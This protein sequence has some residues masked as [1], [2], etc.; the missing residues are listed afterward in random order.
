MN[1]GNLIFFFKKLIACM[2]FY[3]D[4]HHLDTKLEYLGA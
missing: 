2:F 1:Q 3:C 4:E